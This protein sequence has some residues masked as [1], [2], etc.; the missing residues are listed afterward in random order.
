MPSHNSPRLRDGK[1][2]KQVRPEMVPSLT[3]HVVFRSIIKS[4]VL[5]MQQ[6]ALVQF[7]GSIQ[8]N[9]IMLTENKRE[10]KTNSES[11]T[12]WSC[13]ARHLAVERLIKLDVH[14]M[15]Q[16]PVWPRRLWSRHWKSPGP[17]PAGCSQPDCQTDEREQ[18]VQ[19]GVHEWTQG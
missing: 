15:N 9:T 10:R 18:D 1:E 7:K 17:C 4:L 14:A 2:A 12:Q 11:N 5:T 16:Q 13:E 8:I 6:L 19:W 3:G